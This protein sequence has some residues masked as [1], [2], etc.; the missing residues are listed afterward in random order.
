MFLICSYASACVYIDLRKCTFLYIY[1]TSIDRRRILVRFVCVAARYRN[2]LL[3]RFFFEKKHKDI[4]NSRQISFIC[5]RERFENMMKE[6]NLP[7]L[8]L[9]SLAYYMC[10]LGYFLL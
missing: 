2:R 9:Q 3:N 5:E 6:S 8:F 7:H 1:I 4:L 10:K